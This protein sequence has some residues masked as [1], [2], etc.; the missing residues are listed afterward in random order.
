MPPIPDLELIERL[1]TLENAVSNLCE[2]INRGTIT[3]ETIQNDLK[4]IEENIASKQAYV[5][6][7]K[8]TIYVVGLIAV[9]LLSDNLKMLF[10]LINTVVSR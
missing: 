7:I 2:R 10:D 8:T 5:S 1:V 6:G 4:T 9:Y 3:L